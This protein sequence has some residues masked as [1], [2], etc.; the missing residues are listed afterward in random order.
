MPCHF[1]RKEGSSL[2]TLETWKIF[3]VLNSWWIQGKLRAPWKYK[4]INE[5]E[6]IYPE[7]YSLECV[8]CC[9]TNISYSIWTEKQKVPLFHINSP[10]QLSV[11]RLPVLF[12]LRCARRNCHWMT[13][14]IH[15]KAVPIGR[16]QKAEIKVHSYSG[17]TTSRTDIM[18]S[19][20]KQ[21]FIGLSG[22]EVRNMV[23]GTVQGKNTPPCIEQA[24]S[25]DCTRQRRKGNAVSPGMWLDFF[26]KHIVGR[27]SPSNEDKHAVKHSGTSLLYGISLHHNQISIKTNKEKQI[28]L[29]YTA[30]L[31]KAL[32]VIDTRNFR[33]LRCKST[34]LKASIHKTSYKSDTERA[35]FDF[36]NW[37]LPFMSRTIIS[38]PVYVFPLKW[39]V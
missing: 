33:W 36:L 7:T 22:T 23:E 11:F 10:L 17:W 2:F 1:E 35:S 38:E 30:I 32:F 8:I 3:S 12:R 29:S 24:L 39:L 21:T 14:W 5:T 19:G 15:Y 9:N 34:G 18:G 31:G 4:P 27:C 37:K 25:F 20:W 6:L 26:P 13:P 16:Q 28:Q